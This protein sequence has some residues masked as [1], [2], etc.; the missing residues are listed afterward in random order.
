MINTKYSIKLLL[1]NN[2][3]VYNEDAAL[4]SLQLQE[5]SK[6]KN[7]C[8]NKPHPFQIISYFIFFTNLFIVVFVLIPLTQ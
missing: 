7:G 6:K 2:M 3:Q 4:L 8:N 5:I 1:N